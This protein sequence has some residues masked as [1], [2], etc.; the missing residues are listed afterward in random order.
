MCGSRYRVYP[1]KNT[2]AGDYYHWERPVAGRSVHIIKH[3]VEEI[4]WYS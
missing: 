3:I 2:D 4:M 1:L